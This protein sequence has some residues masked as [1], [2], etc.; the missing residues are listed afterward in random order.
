MFGINTFAV[1]AD[2]NG[3][4]WWLLWILVWFE[5]VN[6]ESR[7]EPG[8]LKFYSISKEVLRAN[9]P[10]QKRGGGIDKIFK[11]WLTWWHQQKL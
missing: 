7:V 5:E 6:T 9:L 4:M 8:K 3:D 10:P 11:N 2:S 1:Y